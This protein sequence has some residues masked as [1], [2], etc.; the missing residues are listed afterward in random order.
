MDGGGS[1]ENDFYIGKLQSH[2]IAADTD[3]T[4]RGKFEFGYTLN[5]LV[6]CSD[7]TQGLENIFI[8]LQFIKTAKC[9]QRTFKQFAYL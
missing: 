7:G 9:D 6:A 5:Q 3:L 4:S 8:I 1:I 2:Y